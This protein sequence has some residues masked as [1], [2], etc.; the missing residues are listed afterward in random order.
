MW[1][2]FYEPIVPEP[3]VKP[4]R[5]NIPFHDMHK[6][7]DFKYVDM[8]LKKMNLWTLVTIEQ[9][10]LPELVSQFF[11]TTYFHPTH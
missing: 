10:Y 3:S 7:D 9:D 5:L 6:H 2:Q 1:E 4:R 11:C 8:A